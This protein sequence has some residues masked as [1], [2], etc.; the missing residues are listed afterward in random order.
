MAAAHR[1][2]A[3]VLVDGA[4]AVS[5]M[6]VDVRAIGSDFYVFSGHKVFGPTGIGVLYG[7]ADAFAECRSGRAAATRS[8]R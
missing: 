4:Q 6:R 2:G 7:T 3:R 8:A 1:I 5:H